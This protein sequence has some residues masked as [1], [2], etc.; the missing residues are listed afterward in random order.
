VLVRTVIVQHQMQADLPGELVVQTAQKAQ[1]LLVSMPFVALSNH[2]EPL[3]A[4]HD[5]AQ[6]AFAGEDHETALVVASNLSMLCLKR[7]EDRLNDLGD[8]ERGYGDAWLAGET[9]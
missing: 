1:E 3:Q 8:H 5:T 7:L 4:I 6:L 2:A 9:W